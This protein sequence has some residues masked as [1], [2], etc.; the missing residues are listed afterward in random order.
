MRAPLKRTVRHARRRGDG[1]D[2]RVTL[3]LAPSAAS[4]DGSTRCRQAGVMLVMACAPACTHPDARGCDRGLD[5][6]HGV[7]DCQPGVQRTTGGVDVHLNLVV[8]SFWARE[9]SWA[10][11]RFATLSSMGVPT[12]TMRFFE[13]NECVARS[14]R[15]VCSTTIGTT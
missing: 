10:T 5:Q 12:K 3:K 8:G 15:L 14:P 13:S 4:S 1:T 9:S 11:I 2:V 7:V 6:V